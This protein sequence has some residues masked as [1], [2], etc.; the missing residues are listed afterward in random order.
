MYKSL[1]VC[2]AYKGTY[3]SHL[4][5]EDDADPYE[6]TSYNLY[7]LRYLQWYFVT[8]R[9]PLGKSIEDRGNT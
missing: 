4:G 9:E 6:L 5:G 3:C 2:S 8:I 1:P 7:S